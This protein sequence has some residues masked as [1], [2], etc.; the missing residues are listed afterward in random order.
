MLLGLEPD[1]DIR[2]RLRLFKDAGFDCFFPLYYGQEP[3]EQWAEAAAEAGLFIETLHAPFSRMNDMWLPGSEGDDY[4]AFLK[5]RVDGCARIAVPLCV[6]H[7]TIANQAPPVCR[8]GIERFRRL[9]DY[10]RERGVR[11]AFENL[12]IPEHLHV[13]LGDQASYHGFCWDCGHN[14]CYTPT[15]DMM[16]F[17]GKR[18][19]CMHV[20]DNYGL[21]TPGLVTY[22]D[23]LHLMP[24][25]GGLNWQGF[26]ERIQAS[27]FEGPLTLELSERHRPEYRE[28]GLERFV[29]LAY[30]RADRLRRMCDGEASARL[31]E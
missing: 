21:R 2:S 9:G 1:I 7:V 4:L 8:L 26:A 12:E 3:I 6:M 5:T 28:M 13:V 14:Y 16:A 20:H 23:D 15:V 30:E 31:S 22:H 17:Y 19:L 27:G 11:L 29:A 18:M 25:D 24:F 10:A